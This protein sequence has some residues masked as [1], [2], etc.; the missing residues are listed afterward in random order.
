[1]CPG[2]RNQ[3]P[4]FALFVKYCPGAT[5]HS[6]YS[7]DNV[8]TVLLHAGHWVHSSEQSSWNLHSRRERH[9][10][11]PNTRE[12]VKLHLRQQWTSIS[13]EKNMMQA[14]NFFVLFIFFTICA[15]KNCL[16]W[17]KAVNYFTTCATL[18]TDNANCRQLCNSSV[19]S[20]TTCIKKLLLSYAID[21]VA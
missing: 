19:F 4:D 15:T 13:T 21:H 6:I 7:T 14:F 8:L 20:T 18:Q 10:T 16:T 12:G 1:M 5:L 3:E 9:I 2:T 17:E 11:T